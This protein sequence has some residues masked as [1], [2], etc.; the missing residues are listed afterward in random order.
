VTT[1]DIG[2]NGTSVPCAHIVVLH[3]NALVP[4]GNESM[5]ENERWHVIGVGLLV[6]WAAWCC[7]LMGNGLMIWVTM[8]CHEFASS[9][10]V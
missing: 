2:D 4:C 10:M 6:N 3:S 5:R 9:I 8:P 7:V 1:Q